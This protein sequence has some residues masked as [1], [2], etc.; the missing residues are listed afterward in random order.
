MRK[1]DYVDPMS[2]DIVLGDRASLKRYYKERGVY[3]RFN[4]KGFKLI[5][6]GCYSK[7]DIVAYNDA[8]NIAKMIVGYGKKSG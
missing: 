8:Y 5:F 6:K 7:Y 2:G 4:Y 1:N 3:R